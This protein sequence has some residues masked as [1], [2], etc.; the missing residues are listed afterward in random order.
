MGVSRGDFVKYPRTPHLFGSRGTSD[1][2]HLGERASVSFLADDS[3]IVEEKIDGTN[4]GIH[5]AGGE[6]MLQCRGH[7]ISEGMHSQYDLFK[8]WTRVKR[9]V[10]EERLGERFILYGEWMYAKHSIHYRELPH[11]FFEFDIYDKDAESFLTLER[12]I[13]LLGGTEIETVPIVHRGAMKRSDLEELI[14]ASAF[15]AEFDNPLT[16]RQDDLAEGLYLRTENGTHVTGR[17]KFVRPEFVEKIKQSTH[18]Q[19]KVMVPNEL[20]DGVDFWK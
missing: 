18:W 9:N 1:D 7:L 3:L 11:Y 10:L 2:K 14:Q 12:R 13:E 20:V 16:G 6:L 8:Q 19:Q 15:G 4:V 17:A 5:F